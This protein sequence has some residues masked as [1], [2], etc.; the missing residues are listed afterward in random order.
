MM[1]LALP[2]LCTSRHMNTDVLHQLTFACIFSFSYVW[3]PCR[4]VKQLSR[5]LI[6]LCLCTSSAALICFVGNQSDLITSLIADGAHNDHTDG[7]GRY[8]V[9]T[10]LPLSLFPSLPFP[11]L[12]TS[13]LSFSSPPPPPLPLSFFPFYTLSPSPPSPLLFPL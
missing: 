13:T 11:L 10:Y 1:S 7:R 3:D 8:D 5:M 9:H 4:L 12:F 2:L 6:L